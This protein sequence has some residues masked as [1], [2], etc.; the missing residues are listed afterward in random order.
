MNAA[1]KD[2]RDQVADMLDEARANVGEMGRD[3]SGFFER[4]RNEEANLTR[5]LTTA[6]DARIKADFRGAAVTIAGIRSTSTSGL[7]GA[8]QNW[9]VAAGKRIAEGRS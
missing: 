4:R 2:L 8:V 7:F 1:L 3:H 9:L 6:F 5:R